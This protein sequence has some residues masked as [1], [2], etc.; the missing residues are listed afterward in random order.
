[1]VVI[2]SK[3]DFADVMSEPMAVIDCEYIRV[4]CSIVSQSHFLSEA[5]GFSCGFA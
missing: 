5:R 4:H 3:K 2:N 1:M